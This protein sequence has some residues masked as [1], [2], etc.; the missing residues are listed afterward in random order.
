MKI[1]RIVLSVKK[2]NEPLRVSNFG[3]NNYIEYES[4]SDGSKTLSGEEYL[5]KIRS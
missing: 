4:N 3:G 2:K 5:N 1:I